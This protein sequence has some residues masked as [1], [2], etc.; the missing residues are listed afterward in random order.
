M[1][2]AQKGV[3]LIELMI[4]IAI[5]GVLLVVALPNFTIWMQNTKIRNAA[6]AA[7]AGLQLARAEAARRNAPIALVITDTAPIAANVNKLEPSNIGRNWVLRVYQGGGDY[8][9]ADFIQGAQMAEPA[10]ASPIDVQRYDAAGN[11]L[12]SGKSSS[13]VDTVIF[14][15]LGRASSVLNAGTTVTDYV[16][17]RLD[18]TNPVGGNC[19]HAATPG[20]MRCLR[21]VV[22][23]G[24]N[25]RM[26]D[27]KVTDA[28]DPRSC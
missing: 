4:G 19:Q 11:P 10:A 3:T 13:L 18:F 1:A 24:G 5:L 20:P 17:I 2:S 7:L 23:R 6:E 28:T 25:V 12:A 21:V 22:S 26:C 9:P 14:N 8:A 27:P 15:S 16:S